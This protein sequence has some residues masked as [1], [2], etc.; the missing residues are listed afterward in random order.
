MLKCDCLRERK[1]IFRGVFRMGVVTG[2][3]GLREEE[4][5]REDE[6][7]KSGVSKGAIS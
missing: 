2:V 6:W 4:R 3:L 7:W 1:E 5:K